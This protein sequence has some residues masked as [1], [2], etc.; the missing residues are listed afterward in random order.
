LLSDKFFKSVRKSGIAIGLLAL[1]FLS[2][3]TFQP[4]YAPTAYAP[5]ASNVVGQ[6]VALAQVGV[7]EVDTRV[8]Q[9]VR[10]HLL[11]LFQGGN[12]NPSPRYEARLQVTSFKRSTAA[13]S[14]LRDTTAGI[15][16]VTSSY[17][18]IDTATQNRVAGGTRKATA[19]YDR[20]SQLFA[21]QRAVR[22]AENRAGRDVAEQLRLAIASD[23][24]N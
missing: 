18:L 14:S 17:S 23:L 7:R 22:D 10:N 19:S 6:S 12:D 11:F 21:N 15:V 5:S 9:Q 16:V 1:T 3:C 4:L 8:A 2:A 20:T 24:R 13:Q